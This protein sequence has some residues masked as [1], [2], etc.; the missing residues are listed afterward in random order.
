MPMFSSVFKEILRF[1]ILEIIFDDPV[2]TKQHINSKP[3]QIT[4]K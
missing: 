4:D 3:F 2:F 1:E